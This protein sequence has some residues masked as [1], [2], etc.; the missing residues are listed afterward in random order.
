MSEQSSLAGSQLRGGGR[1][2]RPPP[3]PQYEDEGTEDGRSQSHRS[4]TDGGR[5][6]GE[7][8][9][10]ITG[11]FRP[12]LMVDRE[13]QLDTSLLVRMEGW[14]YKKGGV[15]NS[16]GGRRNWKRRYFKLEPVDY[17]EHTAYE[18]KYYDDKGGDLKGS[19]SLFDVEIYC[20]QKSLHSKVKFEFQILL[21]NGGVLQLS[22]DEEHEREEW[23]DTLN[24]VIAY[25][26]KLTSNNSVALNGYDPLYDDH[27][28]VYDIGEEIGQQSRAYGP[29]IFG[30]EAGHKSSFA[31]QINDI[32]GETVTVGGMP[33]T[34][35][36]SNKDLLYY[37]RV[38][39]NSDGTYSC[40]YAVVTPGYYELAIK[41]NDEHHIA[42][43]P[44]HVQVLPSKT[45]PNFCTAE[46]ACLT[47][48]NP[49][50][51]YSF[52]IFAKDLFNNRKV[53]GGD[54]FEIG[55]IGPGHLHSLSDD[56]DGS[57]TCT[58]ELKNPENMS[59]ITSKS[60]R[61]SVTLHGK[62]IIGS[63]FTPTII[64]APNSNSKYM[65][66]SQVP[67]PQPAVVLPAK[68]EDEQQSNSSIPAVGSILSQLQ[69]SK[70]Q[71]A[72]KSVDAPRSSSN[73]NNNSNSSSNS[74]GNS[75]GNNNNTGNN[76]NGNTTTA[77]SITGT[78]TSATSKNSNSNPNS[79]SAAPD[80]LNPNMASARSTTTVPLTAVSSSDSRSLG[81]ASNSGGAPQSKL[82]RARQKALMIKSLQSNGG[83][84]V[85]TAE[86]PSGAAAAQR[87]TTSDLVGSGN[88]EQ[89]NQN[90]YPVV[91]NTQV[92][93]ISASSA[94]A[95]ATGPSRRQSLTGQGKIV[96]KVV[97]S[98]DSLRYLA[99]VKR[100][101]V[102]N[103]P[104]T[105][106]I[107]DH[108]IWKAT[109]D[110]LGASEEV[111]NI[112]FR[113]MT[114]FR[115]L[116]EAFYEIVDGI[117]MIRTS[118]EKNTGF[119]RMLEEYN[120]MPNEVN[121]NEVKSLFSLILTCQR[122][123]GSPCAIAGGGV[124]LD[125]PHFIKL[126]VMLALFAF[127]KTGNASKP[128]YNAAETKIDSLFTKWVMDDQL[129]LQRLKLQLMKAGK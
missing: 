91:A 66:N 107:D 95:T 118:N 52:K 111:G 94:A 39:D 15:V 28:D 103:L 16:R 99:E 25:I 34:V 100:G 58:F 104:M 23:M 62:H 117:D 38:V 12:R 105:A 82:E 41:I 30:A 98:E 5:G 113:N 18:L 9:D 128:R 116:F 54:P 68:V 19:V 53:T 22:C 109:H 67:A 112:I 89:N 85:S 8:E 71:L 59:F 124:G 45:I 120:I 110:A 129:K 61:I 42:D 31:I 102:G 84:A 127:S 87:L 29:G 92:V 88:S 11:G 93:P 69:Q 37:I 13:G 17:F 64:N 51:L 40:E 73:N 48:L 101:F 56:S 21:Q 86:Q 83:S 60:I 123:I 44:F 32:S 3:P 72:A 65:S 33:I 10:D 96:K 77:A 90:S 50:G 119:Y 46:G 2:G 74:I 14:I 81:S 108:N 24:M 47:T 1:R 76:I 122:N 43:S 26:R 115:N 63:P 126:M 35:T 36:L 125:F 106:T 4:G 20:E 121:K 78:S 7:D 114:N 97:S 75:V 27:P 79:K 49:T 70:Q 6:G 57:Y 55:I 80:L